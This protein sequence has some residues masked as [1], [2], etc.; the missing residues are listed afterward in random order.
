MRA[1]DDV[2]GNDI[3]DLLEPVQRRSVQH[4]TLKR[5]GAEHPVEAA[6]P[7]SRYQQKPLVAEMI[8]IPHLAGIFPW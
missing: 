2:A 8:R 5:N 7:V 1:T 4:L 3:F 6:L